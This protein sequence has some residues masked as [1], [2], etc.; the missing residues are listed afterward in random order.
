MKRKLKAEDIKI[1][2]SPEEAAWTRT[3]EATKLAVE[4]C[5][6]ELEIN[7]NIV[8]LAKSKIDMLQRK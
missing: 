1:V 2:G 6:I 4:T 8:E 7:K 3:L 5:K